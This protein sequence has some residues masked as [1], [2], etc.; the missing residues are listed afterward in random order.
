MERTVWNAPLPSRT[1]KITVAEARLPLYRQGYRQ[2]LAPFRCFHSLAN[3]LRL[4]RYLIVLGRVYYLVSPPVIVFQSHLLSR[5]LC[6][7]FH[8]VLIIF[9]TLRVI[10]SVHYTSTYIDPGLGILGGYW[11]GFGNVAGDGLCVNLT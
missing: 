5:V 10:A 1:V 11:K 2:I 3:I 9:L 8:P 6:M 7:L 4:D